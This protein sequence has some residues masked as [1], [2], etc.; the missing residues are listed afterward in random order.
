MNK[1]NFK[2]YTASAGSGKT[3]TLV[4]EFLTLSLSSD[5]VSCK[6]ILAVTF[7]NKAANEMKAKILST[8]DGF[9][10]NDDNFIDMKRDVIK[11]LNVDENVLVRRAKALYDNILHNYSDFNISTIDSFVQQ[12]SRSFAKELNLPA[13]YRVLLDDDDL[14]DGLIQCVDGRIDK[15]DDSITEILIDFVDFQLD[16]ENFPRVDVSI[17]EFVSKLLKESAYKKGELLGVKELSG[18]DYQQIKDSLNGLYNKC[19]TEV[20]NDIQVI[21]DFE[22][23]Y[24]IVDK[25]YNN[26]SRGLPSILTKISKD[27]N[28][29]P[30]SVVGLTIK[31][32]FA[33]S[34]WFSKSINKQKA[35][36]INKSGVDII[37]LYAKLLKDHQH[38]F[39]TNLVRKNL[40]LYA[41]RSALLGVIN[42]Y[43]DDT[44]NVHISE[45]NKRISDILDDCSIPF[46]YE[47]IGAR[48][49]H[50]FIDEFQDTS[51]LQWHNFLPLVNNGLSEDN[52]SLLVGDAKQA[53]YR[54]RNGEVEQIMN[55]P[56]IYGAK[57]N[58][59]Y[60]ECENTL[61]YSLQKESLGYNYR[62]KKNIIDFNNSFFSIS[63]NKLTSENYRKV[64]DDLEQKCPK[65]Y[66]YDGFVSVELFEMDKFSDEG[67]ESPNKLYKDAVKESILDD[68][69]SLKDK[70]FMLRDIAVL[71]RS[72]SDG[73][74]IAEFLSKNNIPVMSSDSILL[75]SS[76]KVRLIVL[77]LK[78]LVDDKNDVDKLSLSFYKNIC[79]AANSYDIQK[80][81]NDD[82]DF[83]EIYNIRNQAYSVYDLCCAIVRLFGKYFDFNIIED[84]FLQYFMNH[85]LE[86]QNSEN[87]GIE[88]FVEHWDK[89]SNSL[90]VK[91]TSDIDAVQIMTIHKSKGLEY[92]VVMYPYVY[93]EV[94]GSFRGSEKWLPLDDIELLKDIKNIDSFI[95]PI[96]KGLVGTEMEQHYT[97]EIEKAAFDD[98]NIMYVAMTRAK[99]LLF[100][101]SNKIQTEEEKTSESYNFF[102]E[103][104]DEDN[105]YFI[106]N[107]YAEGDASEK[108]DANLI[109]NRF[110]TI[111]KDK[112]IKY[113]LG[114]VEYHKDKEKEKKDVL[115]L[116]EGDVPQ[117]LDWTKT[118]EIDSE[119]TMFWVE[120]DDDD[121]LPK[122]WGNLV[123][124]ILSKINTLEDADKV[125]GSYIN[126][127]S[128]DKQK[129]ER[130]RRQLDKIVALKEVKDAYSKEAVVKNEMDILVFD[131]DTNKNEVIRPDRY[132][133]LD[134]KVIL[135]DYKTGTHQPKYNEQLKTYMQALKDMGVEKPI[136]AYLLYINKVDENIDVKPVFLD[137]LF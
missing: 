72:N 127:G 76:D 108:E 27:I 36:E 1:G 97:D 119:P 69:N 103:Y 104:F 83:S 25:D 22:D 29:A 90:Y 46:I 35:D 53:I 110:V 11:A 79:A 41:L 85:V 129:A 17:R 52:M 16:E 49:K 106:E 124:E 101:Y 134:D 7:T 132:A 94:P 117:L 15:D 78:C 112:S 30:S 75:K 21:R 26:G 109:K 77:T 31:K 2:L 12:V 42:Q 95:L 121:Y 67:L 32:I 133:E 56:S 33:G 58:D 114:T 131:K 118:L 8:L 23:E 6:D 111:H 37:A 61:K 59:F 43:V 88:A 54:F 28:V 81:L 123:H 130:L 45:F 68:I 116:K 3:Y 105:G 18:N 91:I 57:N 44:N 125:L 24:N 14:L 71:V 62:S 122:E 4:R 55:L 92:K 80:A 86:W 48:Y 73:S 20:V 100:I 10:H 65:K 96:N 98:F 82:F 107:S 60:T 89:K 5:N 39:L 126:E 13:Q 63:K 47:K 93:T 136:E 87:D 66:S 19:K 34:N 50:F 74:D 9:V 115:E 51:L 70:G 64:Y 99:D 120:N 137:T 38:L 102:M 135:I 113:E 84:E 40:Y 128:I